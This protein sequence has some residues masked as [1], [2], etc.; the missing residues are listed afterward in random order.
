MNFDEIKFEIFVDKLLLTGDVLLISSIIPSI[1][2]PSRGDLILPSRCYDSLLNFL[3]KN[4]PLTLLET[5]RNWPARIYNPIP[6]I[7]ELI[8]MLP[9]DSV[10]DATEHEHYLPTGTTLFPAPFLSRLDAKLRTISNLISYKILNGDRNE[11]EVFDTLLRLRCIDEMFAEFQ[12]SNEK[13]EIINFIK[14]N[15]NFIF[16]INP[17]IT[18]QFLA[19][20]FTYFPTEDVLS[21]IEDQPY[22]CHVYLKEI[23]DINPELTREYQ[24]TQFG[25]FLKFDRESLLDFALRAKSID[26]VTALESLKRL[27]NDF[28]EIKFFLNYKIE[29]EINFHLI[30]QIQNF[31]RLIEIAKVLDDR[32][33]WNA[34]HTVH[35]G[36]I[37][38]IAEM[39]SISDG[40]RPTG[41][42]PFQL[43]LDLPYESEFPE[44]SRVIE[45]MLGK[46]RIH[47]DNSECLL[48]IYQSELVRGK[49]KQT[50]GVLH[51]PSMPPRQ[52]I[53][54]TTIV[55]Q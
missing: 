12:N 28:H 20:Y 8:D 46:A 9:S 42:D 43:V 16:Q 14:I 45:N 24:N 39:E 35:K 6:L 32:K 40:N 30:S 19:K 25:L 29:N 38:Y 50:N 41:F 13:I 7:D 27:P 37:R 54:Y 53:R 51:G 33:I 22:F 4:D 26:H 21:E 10:L 48:R 1:P 55:P 36:D 23:F 44:I 49:A 5:V 2:V 17:N 18:S 11:R 34:I 15:L 47:S 3:V 52:G 31:Q